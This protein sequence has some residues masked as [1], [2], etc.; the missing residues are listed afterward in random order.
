MVKTREAFA[1]SLFST[2]TT[3]VTAS[4][5]DSSSSKLH[6]RPS[7]KILSLRQAWPLLQKRFHKLQNEAGQLELLSRN[8]QAA[9]D[10]LATTSQKKQQPSP[11]RRAAVLVLLVTVDHQPSLL[12]TRR[13]AHL[14]QHAA[15]ISFPGGHHEPAR[16]ATLVDTAVREAVEELYP[17]NNNSSAAAQDYLDRVAAFRNR[18]DVLGTTTPLPSIRGVPVTPVLAA[19]LDYNLKSPITRTFQGDGGSE[20]DLVFAV[21]LE[22][23][24]AR[25]STH[26]I[27][28]TRFNFESDQ[29]PIY[30]TAHGDIWGL[31]A[32]ILRPVLRKL[33][34]PVFF[35]GDTA[36]AAVEDETTIT[37]SSSS[38][39][40]E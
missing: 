16:D 7:S 3:S 5:S 36:D 32:Y 13:A 14:S 28:P 9:I 4:S 25:E 11:P 8:N 2:T 10:R 40:S 37:T 34:K 31:T 35:G 12:F 15:E 20:V 26:T 33:W 1:V 18:I 24:V 19:M 22:E 30:P 38:T 39:P 6:H 21:P 23:L 29:A 17:S 27:Q